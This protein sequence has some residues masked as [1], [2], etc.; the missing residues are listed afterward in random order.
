RPSGVHNGNPLFPSDV[1]RLHVCRARSY[2]QTSSW[3][4]PLTVTATR[5][6]SGARRGWKYVPP[7]TPVGCSAPSRFTHTS[8]LC[9]GRRF[10]GTYAMVP[11]VEK[12]TCGTRFVVV[13]VRR[14][15]TCIT[16]GKTATGTPVTFDCA[17]SNGTAISV[18]ASTYTRCPVG[19][20]R[21]ATP[22]T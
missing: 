10:A 8:V 16:P 20:Y 1:K 6:P 9:C 11:A 14:R 22:L 18:P 3:S 15:A 13:A 12:L 4:S 19:T 21:V 17:R 5:F 7:D 2:H